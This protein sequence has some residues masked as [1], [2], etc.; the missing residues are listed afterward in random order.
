M[1]YGSGEDKIKSRIGD[2]F[3]YNNNQFSRPDSD[4][5]TGLDIFISRN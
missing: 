2:D 4:F 1:G 3:E 5:G